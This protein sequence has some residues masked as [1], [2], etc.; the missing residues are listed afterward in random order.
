MEKT[1]IPLPVAE[2]SEAVERPSRT[3]RLDFEHGRIV[4]MVD[5]LE[6]VVQAVRKA[7][8]TPRFK[9]L[10]YDNQYGNEAED[11]II[12][13]DATED[14]TRAAAEG[15]VVDALRPDTR[16]L[17]VKNFSLEFEAD[18]ATISF[19]VET[20]FGTAPIQEVISK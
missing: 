5:G 19:E 10:I 1:F 3:Y 16:I 18:S 2:V 11:A 9:C 14:Y 13:E 8:I 15:F 6:A 7:I 4:G 17:S 12:A 20:I